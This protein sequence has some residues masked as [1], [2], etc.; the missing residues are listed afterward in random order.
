MDESLLGLSVLL[1]IDMSLALIRVFLGSLM[2]LSEWDKK[3]ENV[4]LF[5]KVFGK[6]YVTFF[7]RSWKKQEKKTGLKETW[8]HFV[9]VITVDKIYWVVS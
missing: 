9:K 7:F 5:E 3:E 4:F 6:I 8:M 1:D 2:E